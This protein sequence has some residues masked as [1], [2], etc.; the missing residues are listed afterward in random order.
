MTTTHIEHTH[1]D[2]SARKFYIEQRYCE[3][4]KAKKF[5]RVNLDDLSTRCLGCIQR[6]QDGK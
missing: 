1:K 3:K 5:T 2:P 6:E 4:C